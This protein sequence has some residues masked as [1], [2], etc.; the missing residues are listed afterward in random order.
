MKT[1]AKRHERFQLVLHNHVH[2]GGEICRNREGS[3]CPF[4]LSNV[5]QIYI[6]YTRLRDSA[7]TNALACPTNLAYQGAEVEEVHDVIEYGDGII[8]LLCSC[9]DLSS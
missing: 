8:L 3:L 6:V 4:N 2:R 5:T 7:Y 1:T 9:E